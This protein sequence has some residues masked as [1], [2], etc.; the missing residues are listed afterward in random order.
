[1]T[2]WRR[3]IELAMTDEEIE[4]LRGLSRSRTEPAR[5]VER[6][7][8]LLA[9][10]ETPSFYAVG[11][12]LG[13]HHQT[14]ERCVERAL[15]HGPLAALD[16]RPH[17]GKEPTITPEARAWLVSLACD[18]AKEHGYPHELWT[19]RLL[20]RHAR[21]HGPAAGHPCLANLV[22][23]TVCKILGKEEIKPH[24]VRY[25]LENR[26]AEFEQKMAEV[27]CVYR[28]VAVLKKTSA[29]SKKQR[30]AVAIVSCDE[31]PGIQAIAITSPDLPPVPGTYTT[32]SRDHEYKRHGTLSLLAGIDL[33]T[34]KVHALVRDRHRSREFIEFLKLLDTAYPART[35]IKLILDNHSAHISRETTAWLATRPADR[36][37]FTFTPK[38]GS[39][40]NLIEGFFSKFARSVLRHIRVASKYELKQRIMAGIDDVNRHPVV[41][42]W[43]YKLA[44]AA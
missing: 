17:P 23:G 38:H 36:F 5:R 14:V 37:E 7:R 1:M 4:S 20:A 21:E 9:Y 16:D 25:Y 29:K 13:V 26:D 41:H 11:Q 34:G 3:A 44:D 30:N 43:S 10:R 24:K 33:L 15:A 40:L 8:M 6:A 35:A 42:S 31:K 28:E 19:T 27:L 18:K 12:S 2:R 39:W 32:F 22:Q